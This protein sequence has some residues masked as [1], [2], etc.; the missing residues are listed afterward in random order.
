MRVDVHLTVH[1]PELKKLGVLLMST[2]AEVRDHMA[3]LSASVHNINLGLD[4]VRQIVQALRDQI[5]AGSPVS[6]AD[7]DAL[8][9]SV[10]AAQ[11][12]AGEILTKEDTI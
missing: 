10:S 4:D 1:V 11:S 8:D 12:E 3:A 5:A 7:L 2:F 9:A 6:Q